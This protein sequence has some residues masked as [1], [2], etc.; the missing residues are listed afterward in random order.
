MKKVLYIIVCLGILCVSCDKGEKDPISVEVEN[1]DATENTD[2]SENTEESENT[3]DSDGSDGSGTTDESGDDNAPWNF[4]QIVKFTNDEYRN[5]ILAEQIGDF[6]VMMRGKTPPVVEELIVGSIPYCVKLPNGYWLIDWRWGG[7]FIYRPSNVLLS[8]KWETLIHWD[9]TWVMPENPL[10]FDAYIVDV[11]GV[12]I[13]TIDTYL[14]INLEVSRFS[15]YG[16][17]L[18]N[19]PWV[20]GRNY[21]SEKDIP[22][23]EKEHYYDCIHQQDSLQ[24]I[25]TQRLIEIINS[26]NFDKVY[27]VM[28]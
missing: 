6:P 16:D 13:R 2:E 10:A 18:Y 17:M 15:A 21:V 9:Q 25:Y 22:I 26:G 27:N 1:T 8:D 4:M 12:F 14:G 3:D 7:V 24:K 11:G 19:R 5:Y 23:N 20:F 28:P